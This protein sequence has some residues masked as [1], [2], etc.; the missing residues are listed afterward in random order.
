MASEEDVEQVG[1]WE[2]D[3]AHVGWG[4]SVCSYTAVAAA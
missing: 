4:A 3:T 1:L 2:P